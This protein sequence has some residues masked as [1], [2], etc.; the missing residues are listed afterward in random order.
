[1]RRLATTVLVAAV[2][3]A[4]LG[5]GY[6]TK[7]KKVEVHAWARAV[8][9]SVGAWVDGA[10][11]GSEELSQ[12]LAASEP[13]LAAIQQTLASYIAATKASTD[14]VIA[15]VR[16]A[17]Y[18]DTPKGRP[19]WRALREG[20]AQVRGVFAE[21]ESL[22][23]GLPVEDATAFQAQLEAVKTQLD[24]GIGEFSKAFDR[25]DRLDPDQ[26]LARAFET[27]ATCRAL[28]PR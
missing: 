17:G 21:G 19:A 6:P 22:I 4:L 25:L 2:T 24:T 26:K 14:G 18:P 12:V 7:T 27:T 9:T 10:Q 15:D 1:M 3:V 28:E 23:A 13:D 11:Q 20:F 5:A 16:H 8:C